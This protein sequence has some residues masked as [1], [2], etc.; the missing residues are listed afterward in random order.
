M[1]KDLNKV[2]NGI[3]Q[4]EKN[5]ESSVATDETKKESKF[6]KNKPI[7]K[8]INLHNKSSQII[9]LNEYKIYCNEKSNTL[10]NKLDWNI[11]ESNNDNG[12]NDICN[13]LNMYY[14]EKNNVQFTPEF[15][16]FVLGNDGFVMSIVS[17]DSNIICGVVCTSIKRIIVLD[18]NKKFAYI[19]FL[20]THPKFKKKGLVETL[21]NE[22]IRYINVNKKIQQGLFL[23][24]NKISQSCAT[25][26]KYYR[27][28]NYHKLAKSNFLKLDGKENAIH[29]KFSLLSSDYSDNYISMKK[30][31]IDKVYDLYKIYTSQYN[32][33]VFYTKEDLENLLLNNN[34]VKSYVILSESTQE[35]IDFVSYYHMQYKCENN[36]TINAGYLF[37]Y[38]LLNEYS[39]SLLNNLIK[40]MN[41]NNIDIVYVNDDKSISNTLLTEKYDLNEDSD[42]ESYD[43]IFEHK[44]IK[45]EKNYIYLFNWECPYLSPE[46]INIDLIL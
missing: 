39:E 24:N 5:V 12:L 38:S 41:K 25:I 37:L 3:E 43:K 22:L 15:L 10:P 27:P 45:D 7:M 16:K 23:T 29:N 18:R 21:L 42:I 8:H 13:F 2:T 31:H 20:C 26:R 32:M 40:I 30:E 6:W 28:I 46:K 35:V 44:F 1:N 34:I 11:T 33:S 9:N 4:N 19:N 17:K 14:K 36:E